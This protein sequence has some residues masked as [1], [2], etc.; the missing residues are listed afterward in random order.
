M[1][2]EE[3]AFSRYMTDDERR[4]KLAD[5]LLAN[6]VIVPPVA[7]GDVVYALP[8]CWRKEGGISAFQIT[9]FII[10]HNKKGIWTKKY[11]AMW[12]LNGKTRDAQ[13]NFWFDDI[14]KTVFLSREEAEKALE[15]SRG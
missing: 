3:K 15:R 9:N 2:E 12:L 6:G 4:E 13:I 11:R 14:G 8:P 1:L 10:S 7:V 5:H